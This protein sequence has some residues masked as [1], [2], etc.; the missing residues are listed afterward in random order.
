MR[1]RFGKA[2]GEYEW[3]SEL[4]VLSRA[5]VGNECARDLAGITATNVRLTIGKPSDHIGEKIVDSTAK[6]THTL[7]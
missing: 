3:H 2:I 4:S 1:C 6:A 5:T 7:E